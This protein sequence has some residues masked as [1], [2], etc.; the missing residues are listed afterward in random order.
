MPEADV[1]L[2]AQVDQSATAQRPSACAGVMMGSNPTPGV[3]LFTL[4]GLDSTSA[5]EALHP[6]WHVS[7]IVWHVS[8]IAATVKLTAYQHTGPVRP[9]QG[10]RG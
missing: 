8:A 4:E 2:V 7:V 3:E 1:S 10:H 9:A 6:G 5:A